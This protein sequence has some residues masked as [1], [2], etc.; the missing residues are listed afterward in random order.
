MK[1][2]IRNPDKA[3][4]DNFYLEN[5]E[6]SEVEIRYALE[7]PKPQNG[8]CLVGDVTFFWPN[9]DFTPFV[10]FYLGLPERVMAFCDTHPSSW[11]MKGRGNERIFSLCPDIT[12]DTWWRTPQNT[13]LEVDEAIEMLQGFAE[14]EVATQGCSFEET[15]ERVNEWIGNLWFELGPDHQFDIYEDAFY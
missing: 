8:G 11:V 5:E 12:P 1:M 9:R 15:C 3:D 7:N 6:P 10:R 2:R 14:L 13:G 4:K